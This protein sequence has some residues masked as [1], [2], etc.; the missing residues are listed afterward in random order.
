[1]R[2]ESRK[3]GQETRVDIY[4]KITDRIIA[5]LEVGV[6]PWVQP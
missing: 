1:M 5:S 3:N 4:A 2:Q 6:R